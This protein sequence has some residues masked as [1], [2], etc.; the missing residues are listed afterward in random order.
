[1]L[2]LRDISLYEGS[3]LPPLDSDC[4][5]IDV[6]FV[7]AWYFGQSVARLRPRYPPLPDFDKTRTGGMFVTASAPTHGA[8]YPFETYPHMAWHH[9]SAGCTSFGGVTNRS[10]EELYQ[11]SGARGI[12]FFTDQACQGSADPEIPPVKWMTNEVLNPF[13]TRL[14]DRNVS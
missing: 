3:L 4:R 13:G 1:M 12:W 2:S 10:W 6:Y 5:H 11:T 7:A 9:T 8:M 14:A